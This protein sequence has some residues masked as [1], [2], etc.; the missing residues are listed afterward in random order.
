MICRQ[1]TEQRL[2]HLQ[3]GRLDA[4]E[5]GVVLREHAEHLGHADGHPSVAASPEEG[6]SGVVVEK[7]VGA[8][9]AVEV[10]RHLTG[11][12]VDVLFVARDQVGLGL[13]VGDH[14]HVVDPQPRLPRVSLV[15]VFLRL[16]ELLVVLRVLRQLP[17]SVGVFHAQLQ[18][19]RVVVALVDLQGHGA[20]N[21]EVDDVVVLGEEVG[22]QVLLRGEQ[23][24]ET[25][26]EPGVEAVVAGSGR[27]P[28]RTQPRADVGVG[29]QRDLV[30]RID[31]APVRMRGLEVAFGESHADL[32]GLASLR[33]MLQVVAFLRLDIRGRCE[34]QQGLYN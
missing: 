30:F 8:L 1:V 34:Q 33:E 29:D 26:H 23:R 14:E 9:D 28:Q 7:P 31:V 2:H 12:A 20:E 17:L 27:E 13:Q 4:R 6:R 16:G 24:L 11:G 10:E 18:V 5:I 3:I 22:L 19:F 25:L 32:F 15:G 21:V